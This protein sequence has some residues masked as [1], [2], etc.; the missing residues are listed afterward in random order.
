MDR[1]TFRDVL[2]DVGKAWAWLLDFEE[3]GDAN[4]YARLKEV[5]AALKL[6]FPNLDLREMELAIGRVFWEQDVARARDCGVVRVGLQRI[7]LELQPE[8]LR[9]SDDYDEIARQARRSLP[10]LQK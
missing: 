7:F 5:C 8:C 3:S 10:P 2:E 4:S 1:Q 9:Y 6:V